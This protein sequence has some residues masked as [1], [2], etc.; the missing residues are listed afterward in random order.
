[1]HIQEDPQDSQVVDPNLDNS[2]AMYENYADYDKYDEGNDAAY[3]STMMT[4]ANMYGNKGKH[5]IYILVH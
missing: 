1:M 4:A 2:M 3:D 5:I